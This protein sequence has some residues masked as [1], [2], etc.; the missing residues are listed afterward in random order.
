[1]SVNESQG[2]VLRTKIEQTVSNIGRVS[3]EQILRM[4]RL[5]GKE[6]V[7]HHVGDLIKGHEVNWDEERNLLTARIKPVR[8]DSMQRM[9]TS[10]FWILAAFGDE[11][12]DWFIPTPPPCQL[13]W[14]ESKHYRLFDVTYVPPGQAFWTGESWCRTKA[15]F[16]PSEVKNEICDHIAL[17]FNKEDG[18]EIMP[19]GFTRYCLLNSSKQPVFYPSLEI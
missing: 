12:I 9:L 5:Y 7:M 16:F 14:S 11:N 17:V 18:E 1:M 4:Y 15:T 19:Y 3:P 10:A 6:T 8:N 2:E 13:L